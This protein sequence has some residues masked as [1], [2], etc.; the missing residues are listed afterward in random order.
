MRQPA[1]KIVIFLAEK[2]NFE[3]KPL[4]GFTFEAEGGIIKSE[5]YPASYDNEIERDA[6]K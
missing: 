6:Q 4:F 2:P 3:G 1:Q 5:Y